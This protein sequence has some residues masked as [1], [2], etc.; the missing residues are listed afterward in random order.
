MKVKSWMQKISKK[1][2]CNNEI[3]YQYAFAKKKNISKDSFQNKYTLISIV[4]KIH[5]LSSKY[6][7]NHH[8]WK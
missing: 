4:N 2:C 7:L 8:V 3:V 1:L 5:Q 6:I